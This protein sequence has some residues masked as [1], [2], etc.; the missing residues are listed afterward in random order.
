MHLGSVT[1]LTHHGVLGVTVTSTFLNT[2][3]D[4]NIRDMNNGRWCIVLHFF[5]SARPWAF[6]WKIQK[7]SRNRRRNERAPGRKVT[8]FKEEKGTKLT[9][10]NKIGSWAK[11][12]FITRSW[13]WKAVWGP[14][15]CRAHWLH[16]QHRD[17]SRP[18]WRGWPL[19]AYQRS[20]V[21]PLMLTTD[22]AFSQPISVLSLSAAEMWKVWPWPRPASDWE[23]HHLTLTSLKGCMVA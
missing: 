12:T 2:V 4:P 15:A 13:M 10:D 21:L 3:T 11:L 7:G 23:G 19:S 1:V 20:A 5:R 6:Q 18:P 16:V 8:L 14:S 22:L 17:R 9:R